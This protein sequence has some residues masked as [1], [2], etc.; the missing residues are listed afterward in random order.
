MVPTLPGAA[1]LG[2]FNPITAAQ[3]RGQVKEKAA[4]LAARFSLGQ[5]GLHHGQAAL[6]ELLL[7][8]N[9]P[10]QVAE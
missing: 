5:E 7:A 4:A 9:I 3:V 10:C 8:L 1:G 6:L 2:Q